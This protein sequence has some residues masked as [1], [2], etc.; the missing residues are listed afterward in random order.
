MSPAARPEVSVVV[1][2][3]NEQARIGRT[4]VRALDHLAAHHPEHGELIVVDDGSTDETARIVEQVGGDRVRLLRQPRNSGKGA[5]VRRGVL[6]ARGE[7]V[8]FMDADLSTPIEELEKLLA[9]ARSG[10]DVVI[11]SRG[12]P[13]SDIR[14]R[15]PTPRELMG[16]GFNLIVRTVLFGG[17]RDTQCGFKLFRHDAAREIFSRST[18]DGFA[19]DVEIL[20]IARDL[21]YRIHEVPVIW[22]HAPH[23]KV[24]PVTDASKMFLDVLRLKLKQRR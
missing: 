24:S 19:F 1:P 7:F 6:E 9:F 13:D 20:L 2:A 10:A 4:L 17:V 11:G 15:Q 5:A 23:S 14:Q 21:G 3:Y 12:L 18:V 16:R 8:L 22:Y